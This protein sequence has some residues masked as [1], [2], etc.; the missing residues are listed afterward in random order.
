MKS[1]IVE[2]TFVDDNKSISDKNIN[3]I[4]EILNKISYGC[5]IITMD[6]GNISKIEKE[7]KFRVK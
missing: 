1:F 6:K 4:I 5:L 3:F 7:E 2:S